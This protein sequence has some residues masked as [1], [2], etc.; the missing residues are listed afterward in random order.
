[1]ALSID[2]PASACQTV[3]QGTCWLHGIFCGAAPCWLARG[4]CAWGPTA[5]PGD[6]GLTALL[7]I[8]Q[9]CRCLHLGQLLLYQ[10]LTAEDAA[11]ETPVLPVPLLPPVAARLGLQTQLAACGC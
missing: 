1:M 2:G 5:L 4:H 8:A 10:W 3:K 6:A 9:P 11:A 7:Q